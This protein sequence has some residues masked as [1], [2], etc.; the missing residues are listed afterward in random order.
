MSIQANNNLKTPFQSFA[1]LNDPLTLLNDTA[2][3]ISEQT[4]NLQDLAKQRIEKRNPIVHA[5]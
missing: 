1:D 4:L 3:I 2:N 5:S